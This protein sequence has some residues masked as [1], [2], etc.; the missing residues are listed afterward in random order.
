ML[1]VVFVVPAALLIQV[2][3]VPIALHRHRFRSPHRPDAKLGVA[4]PVGTLYCFSDASSG[5][6]GPSARTTAS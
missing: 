4:K 6:N 1:D 2:A 3:R 5:V